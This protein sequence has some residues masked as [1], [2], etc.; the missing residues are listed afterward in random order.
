MELIC[1]SYSSNGKQF[2]GGVKEQNGVFSILLQDKKSP[3][4]DVLGSDKFLY[5]QSFNEALQYLE[6]FLKE[7]LHLSNIV[8]SNQKKGVFNG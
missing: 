4:Y 1:Y 5:F 7:E 8:P 3:F 6:W 2:L